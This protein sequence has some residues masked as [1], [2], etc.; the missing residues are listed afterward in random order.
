M[1]NTN[2]NF[3]TSPTA[4]SIGFVV[5]LNLVI[6]LVFS[7]MVGFDKFLTI[8]AVLLA[9]EF[10]IFIIRMILVPSSSFADIYNL[11]NFLYITSTFGSGIV[12]VLG[13]LWSLTPWAN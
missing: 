6:S 13:W 2:T 7:L 12:G 10:L 9:I 1:S 11:N 8:F 4:M 3:I 5:L